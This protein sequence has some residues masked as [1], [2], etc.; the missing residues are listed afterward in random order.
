MC[1]AAIKK[2]EN[3]VTMNVCSMCRNYMDNQNHTVP[4]CFAIAN[5]N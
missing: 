2:H 1:F 3:D 4:P 5:G